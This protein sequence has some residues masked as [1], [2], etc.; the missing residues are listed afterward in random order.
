MI[1]KLIDIGDS[2]KT[3]IL[4]IPVSLLIELGWSVG[5]EVV[6]DIPS[7][8]PDQLVIHKKEQNV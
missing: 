3:L 1:I 8:Y 6:M 5:D 4:P 2:A 7:S